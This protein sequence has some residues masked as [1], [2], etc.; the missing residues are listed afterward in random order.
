M[1]HNGWFVNPHNANLAVNLEQASTLDLKDNKVIIS[2]IRIWTFESD[3][4]AA[5]VFEQMIRTAQQK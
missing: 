2:G 3:T 1:T 5:R 4:V